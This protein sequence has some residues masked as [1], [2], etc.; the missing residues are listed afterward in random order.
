MFTPGT[1]VGI[2][3]GILI[4]TA[5]L[6]I[7]IGT[8]IGISV[9]ARTVESVGVFVIFITFCFGVYTLVAGTSVFTLIGTS[10]RTSIGTVV[11]RTALFSEDFI[12]VERIVERMGVSV[13]FGF[14]MFTLR[15]STSTGTSLR[16]ILGT[17]VVATAATFGLSEVLFIVLFLGI[18]AATVFL[19]I[20]F[21]DFRLFFSA[22]FNT[23]FLSLC[24]SSVLIC[25]FSLFSA[26]LCSLCCVTG[27]AAG[28]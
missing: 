21:I 11:A 1:S 27:D 8:L 3:I 20:L 28:V 2:T 7:L 17:L 5:L 10:V 16:T 23:P 13:T 12:I 22:L 9:V 18:L 6:G 19:S 14:R 4:E 15:G 24:I 26:S 25:S